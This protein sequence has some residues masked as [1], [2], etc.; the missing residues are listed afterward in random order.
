MPWRHRY[1]KEKYVPP[2]SNVSNNRTVSDNR[3]KSFVQVY[4]KSTQGTQR[5]TRYP[6]VHKVS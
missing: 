6:K 4:K 1:I 5:Y 3:T 2:V